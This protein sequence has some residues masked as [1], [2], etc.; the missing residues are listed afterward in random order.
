MLAVRELI[1]IA[2]CQRSGAAD[3]SLTA[4]ITVNSMDGVHNAFT[5]IGENS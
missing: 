5:E 4:I 2:V 1:P 3:R